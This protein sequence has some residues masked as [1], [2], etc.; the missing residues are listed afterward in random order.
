MSLYIFGFI[1]Q[2]CTLILASYNYHT[3][4]IVFESVLILI[5]L[6]MIIRYTNK[7]L[8][9]SSWINFYCGKA[10]NRIF[11]SIYSTIGVALVVLMFSIQCGVIINY[12]NWSKYNDFPSHCNTDVD[13]TRITL[14]NSIR[15]GGWTPLTILAAERDELVKTY[16]EN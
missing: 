13:C 5:S 16:L 1:V 9:K 10:P 12:P 6:F 11:I 3:F 4:G 7:C 14:N 8:K 2:L 15:G